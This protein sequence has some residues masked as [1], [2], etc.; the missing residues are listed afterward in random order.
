VVDPQGS[1]GGIMRIGSLVMYAKGDNKR[2]LGTLGVVIKEYEDP[3]MFGSNKTFF[4]VL[5]SDGNTG[6]GWRANSWGLE[7]LCK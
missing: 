5:W 2:L 1:T 7:V 4:V 6:K 3:E